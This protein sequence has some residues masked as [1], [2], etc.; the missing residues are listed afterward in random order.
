MMRNVGEKTGND[1][2]N[3]QKETGNIWRAGERNKM[4]YN[5]DV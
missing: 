3:K 4:Q 1:K 5:K 2:R